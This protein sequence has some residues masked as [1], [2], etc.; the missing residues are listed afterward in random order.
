LNRPKGAA[1]G[2]EDSELKGK[3]STLSIYGYVAE[4]DEELEAARKKQEQ[5]KGEDYDF[6]RV[7]DDNN[8]EEN[9][10]AHAVDEDDEEEVRDH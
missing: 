1:E 10:R 6:E 8:K 7:W 3:A 4:D 2:D 5:E 9:V